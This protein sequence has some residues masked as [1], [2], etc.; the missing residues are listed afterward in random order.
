MWNRG[1]VRIS[2]E[3]DLD[4]DAGQKGCFVLTRAVDYQ[5]S[6]FSTRFQERP[7]S[8]ELVFEQ[9][10]SNGFLRPCETVIKVHGSVEQLHQCICKMMDNS[11]AETSIAS[12]SGSRIPRKCLSYNFPLSRLLAI[13]LAGPS[14]PLLLDPDKILTPYG[15]ATLEVV[16]YLT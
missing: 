16:R 9:A 8:S 5:I 12:H 14:C 10:C 13:R 2:E 1:R 3:V 7:A 15:E 6:I 4:L 11:T